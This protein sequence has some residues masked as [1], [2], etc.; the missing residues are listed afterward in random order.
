MK[1]RSKIRMLAVMFIAAVLGLASASYS[2]GNGITWTQA[3]EWAAFSGRR[4]HT[5]VVF[6]DKMWV[7]GGFEP[8]IGTNFYKNDVWS[9]PD[10]VNWTQETGAAAFPGRYGHTS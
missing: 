10:G 4:S 2:F 9:S 3:T 7:I 5:G 6:N 1:T 8:G